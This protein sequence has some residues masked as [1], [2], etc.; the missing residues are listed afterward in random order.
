[1]SR[2]R[3]FLLLGMTLVLACGFQPQRALA[4]PVPGAAEPSGDAPAAPAE[5]TVSPQL[6]A[7]QNAAQRA[8]DTVRGQSVTLGLGYGQTTAKFGFPSLDKGRAQI[9]D[10]GTLVPLVQYNSPES[11]FW[12]SP[13]KVG[14][15]A[16][17]YNLVANYAA[18]SL[19]RQLTVGPFQGANV[20]TRVTGSYVAAAPMVFVRLGTL[21]P[22]RTIF[23]KFG[24][25]A[26][27]AAVQYKG[28]VIATTASSARYLEPVQFNG[29]S[30]SVYTTEVWELQVE[31]WSL[32]FKGAQSSGSARHENFTLEEYS[33]TLG[34]GFTF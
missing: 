20:G 11:Y 31:R 10:N 8:A 28:T 27:A 23:W 4:Q 21:Y 29:D 30:L 16:L 5:A 9:T 18:F 15:A 12:E 25:G 22:E 6:E 3:H 19:N 32:L 34:Y 2:N 33:L 13:L 14:R 24:V 26:G 1:M 7:L 17:G